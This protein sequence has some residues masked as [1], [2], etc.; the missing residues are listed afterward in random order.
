[1]HAPGHG[2]S[3]AA[4]VSGGH[5]LRAAGP[6]HGA[7]VY[8]LCD[9]LLRLAIGTAVAT[10]PSGLTATWIWLGSGIVIFGVCDSI[11][12]RELATGTY[13]AGGPIDFGWVLGLGLMAIAA[14]SRDRS[15]PQRRRRGADTVPLGG[16]LVALV[17]LQLDDFGRRA[18]DYPA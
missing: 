1:M 12:M 17:I 8:P 18:R 15:R 16:A 10:A 3:R 14:W 7:L 13:K 2:R 9:A 4:A 5:R 6:L 11:Y